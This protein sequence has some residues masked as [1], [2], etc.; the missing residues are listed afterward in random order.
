M[1]PVKV[2]LA[3]DLVGYRYTHRS[4]RLLDG[5][6]VL[7]LFDRPI[8][9]VSHIVKG[10]EDSVLSL[11]AVVALTP[12]AADFGGM[13]SLHAQ[14]KEKAGRRPLTDIKA[15]KEDAAAVE[16]MSEEIKARYTKIFRV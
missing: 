4:F 6:P 16:R 11:V 10:I 7:E 12:M 13:R 5:L 3:P 1:T 8:S 14:V 2:R 15:M 9:G